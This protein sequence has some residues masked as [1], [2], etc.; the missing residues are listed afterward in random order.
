MQSPAGLY[1]PVRPG[2]PALDIIN[3]FRHARGTDRP[4][5]PT[6]SVPY[7]GLR[8]VDSFSW[9]IYLDFAAKKSL[10]AWP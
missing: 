3:G 2:V 8:E 9:Q 4:P 10:T 6:S 5:Y 7:F 1:L